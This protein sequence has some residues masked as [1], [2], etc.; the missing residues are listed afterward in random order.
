MKNEVKGLGL[1]N[2][3]TVHNKLKSVIDQLYC[4]TNP[5]PIRIRICIITYF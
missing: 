1:G 2:D 3:Q 4:L 5:K